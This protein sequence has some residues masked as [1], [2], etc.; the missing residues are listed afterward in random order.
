MSTW[1][2]VGNRGMAPNQPRRRPAQVAP[3]PQPH[4]EI[5]HVHHHRRPAN[6]VDREGW[7]PG[8]HRRRNSRLTLPW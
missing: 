8:R 3:R 7:A 6:K 5:G 4:D 1:L 2:G